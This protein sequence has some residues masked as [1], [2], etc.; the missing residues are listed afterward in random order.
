MSEPGDLQEVIRDLREEIAR[1]QNDLDTTT[2]ERL[3]AAEYGL[4]VLEEKQTLQNQFDELEGIFESTK[5]ELDLAKKVCFVYTFTK[6]PYVSHVRSFSIRVC[7]FL[8][9]LFTA[10]KLIIW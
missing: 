2:Q 5:H 7:I 8:A 10:V 6:S 1:L 3:Q 9:T 4:A